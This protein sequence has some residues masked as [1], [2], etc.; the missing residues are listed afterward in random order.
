MWCMARWWVFTYAMIVC[1][2]DFDITTFRPLAR[3]GYRDYSVVDNTFTLQR[4][5]D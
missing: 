1:A 5:D 2:T 4:P 3:L